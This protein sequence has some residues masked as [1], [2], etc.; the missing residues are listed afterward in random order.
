[1]DL[2]FEHFAEGFR[3]WNQFIALWVWGPFLRQGACRHETRLC[4][5]RRLHTSDA[6]ASASLEVDYVFNQIYLRLKMTFYGIKCHKMFLSRCVNYRYT[7]EDHLV[8]C[9]RIF[10][11]SQLS[12]KIMNYY[13]IHPVVSW[14]CF[15]IESF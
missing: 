3:V 11:F 9:F 6:H 8:C 10:S 14:F 13:E 4:S 7:F 5:P 2:F 12:N 1:M 15:L